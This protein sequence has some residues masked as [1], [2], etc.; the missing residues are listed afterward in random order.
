MEY[1]KLI[2]PK[3]H[4]SWS[5]L[6]CWIS[7]PARY[8]REYFEQ[9]YKLNTKYLRF[10]KGIAKM[11]EENRHKELLPELITYD[12]PEFKIK[13]FVKSIPILSYLDSYDPKNNIF[14]EYKTGKIAWTQAKVQRHDQLTFYATAL[15]WK[16]G[17]IPEYCDLDWIETVEL[18]EKTCG[19]LYNE[20]KV[21]ATGRIVTFHREFDDREIERMEDLIVKVAWEISNAYIRFLEEI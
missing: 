19:G 15:K 17:K 9:G 7:N 13:C 16:L 6:S 20:K 18:S 2:L 5:Q 12:E 1:N 4:I 3:P 8:R 21:N 10:G 14:R 11:I